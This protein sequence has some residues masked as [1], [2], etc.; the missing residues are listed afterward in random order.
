LI[1]IGPDLNGKPQLWHP[2]SSNQLL[3]SD[4]NNVLDFNKPSLRVLGCMFYIHHLIGGD[5]SL[6]SFVAAVCRGEQRPVMVIFQSEIS[7]E[8]MMFRWGD[9][10]WTMIPNMPWF[11]AFV[12]AAVIFLLLLSSLFFCSYY[13]DRAFQSSLNSRDHDF[14]YCLDNFLSS[15]Y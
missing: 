14:T 10:S 1:R 11:L 13:P 4:F 9:D 15:A 8:P 2:F 12:I 3:S 5:Q 6:I 7:W